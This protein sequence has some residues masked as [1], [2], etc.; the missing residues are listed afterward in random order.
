MNNTRYYNFDFTR[1]YAVIIIVF[2]HIILYGNQDALYGVGK[3]LGYCGNVIF[4]AISSILF[5]LKLGAGGGDSFPSLVQFLKTRS[6]KIFSSLW[7]FL[8]LINL[9]YSFCGVKYS[10]LKMFF[11]FIGLSWVAKIDGIGHLWF[12][13][14]IFICYVVFALLAHINNTK[15]WLRWGWLTILLEFIIDA[16]GL[17]GQ[18][19]VILFLCSWLFCN[20]QV[21]MDKVKDSKWKWLILFGIPL[22]ILTLC[23]CCHTHF[24]CE[25]TIK[26]LLSYMCGMFWLVVLLKIGSQ[27]NKNRIIVFLS[28]IS[29]EI[30]L[31]HHP[32]CGGPISL[33]HIV[34]GRWLQ[35]L[36]ICFLS[37]VIGWF[38]HLIGRR[39][40]KMFVN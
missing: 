18:L 26:R 3:F 29:F 31:I 11:N 23:L 39:I 22:N 16:K 12:I 33:A 7:P 14:M 6:I 13:T 1:A 40:S 15:P 17:P 37:I 28:S 19:L 27:V 8:I 30:Y 21:F 9:I 35:V 24:F 10:L 2:C 36:L 4:L 20:A 5:G 32:L 34:S 38:L 25:I